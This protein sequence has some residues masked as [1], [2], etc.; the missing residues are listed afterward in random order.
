MGL[1]GAD[2]RW[3]Y[4]EVDA[5]FTL[6]TPRSDRS[7]ED[8]MLAYDG[9]HAL[10][11]LLLER[12]RTPVLEC[13]YSR[14]EQRTSLLR[15]M[16]CHAAPLWVVELDV[17]AEDA[18]AR[19]HR[20]HQASDLTEQLVQERARTFPRYDQALQLSSAAMTMQDTARQIADW[21]AQPPAAIDGSRWAAT[22]NR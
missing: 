5:L 15:E 7:R 12:G 9:A 6:L 22:G 10:A 20:R 8:R 16:A 1:P 17:S 14:Q 21:L 2:E 4:L 19:F 18:V 13:T 11:C 3:V